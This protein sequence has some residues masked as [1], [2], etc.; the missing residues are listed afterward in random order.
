MFLFYSIVS[1]SY[2]TSSTVCL[3]YVISALWF[4]NVINECWGIAVNVFWRHLKAG[5]YDAKDV[6]G[7]K[8]LIPAQH[9]M[10]AMDRAL[11]HLN[12]LP[13]EYK[14]FYARR[15]IQTLQQK[16]FIPDS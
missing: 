4:H 7:N 9:A 10:Q 8:D 14:D 2:G 15:M 6:Y 16:A 13:A 1:Y 12:T 3:V 11:K 5:Q